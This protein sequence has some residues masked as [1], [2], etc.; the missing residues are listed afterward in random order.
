MLAIT[1]VRPPQHFPDPLGGIDNT[2]RGPVG[3]SLRAVISGIMRRAIE[4]GADG[5][6][7]GVPDDEAT[8]VW[9][10]AA[11]GKWQK[12][13]A[14][15]SGLGTRIAGAIASFA[16]GRK[17]FQARGLGRGWKDSSVRIE[18]VEGPEAKGMAL[19]WARP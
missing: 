1:P 2:H 10:R 8:V 12:Q 6:L 13:L 17:E 9:V 14:L 5:V 15:P 18:T 3:E 4:G 11:G 19:T 16:G 7:I